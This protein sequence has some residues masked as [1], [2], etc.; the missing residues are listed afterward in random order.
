[1]RRFG[2]CL[3]AVLAVGMVAATSAMAHEVRWQTCERAPKFNGHDTG[4][5]T[6]KQLCDQKRNK[7]RRIRTEPVEYR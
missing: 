4:K 5:Y 1:M 3:T 2:L 6:E 7:R